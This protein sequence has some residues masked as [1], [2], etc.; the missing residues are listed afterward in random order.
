MQNRSNILLF[1]SGLLPISLCVAAGIG[2]YQILPWR[3]PRIL[4]FH[5]DGFEVLIYV[6]FPRVILA[7]IVGAA[8]AISGATLQGIF[9]NPLADPGLIGVTAGAGLGAAIWIVLF[10]GGFL[11]IWGVPVAAFTGGILVTIGVWTIAQTQERVP[12][13]TLLLAGIALNSF[14]GAGIGLMTFL[15]DEEQ[16][17]SLTFWLLGGFGGAT[18]RAIAVTLPIAIIGAVVLFRLARALNAMSLG[19]SEAYHLGVSTETLKRWA[20]FGVALAVGAAVSAAGGIGFVGLIVP[21]LLR[22]IGGADHRYVLPGSAIG[23]AALLVTADL[24]ARTVAIPAELPVGVVT[25]LLGGPFFLWLLLR[26]K[27]EV[28]H[29]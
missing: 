23:G 5:E 16:L 3:I 17:R 8:L 21:H 11:G 22:L 28:V 13:L 4:L 29:G 7:T 12:T 27:R 2:A 15:A 9:R 19:E 18:W 25:A 26:F 24:F 10:G 1:L 20:V 6:R 14:A